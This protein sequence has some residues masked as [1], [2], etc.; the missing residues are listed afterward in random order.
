[1]ICDLV[2]VGAQQMMVEHAAQRV[3]PPR[4]ELCEDLTLARNR[5]GEDHIER[6]HTIACNHQ[7]PAVPDIVDVTHLPP[8]EER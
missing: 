6:A 7:E 5:L 8:V 2:R 3:Q 4:R 1:M